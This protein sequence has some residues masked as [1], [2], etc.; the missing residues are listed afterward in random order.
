MEG[1]N[2]NRNLRDLNLI[3]F[4][5]PPGQG[6]VDIPPSAC[7]PVFINFCHS[8]LPVYFVHGSIV[9]IELVRDLRK[10]KKKKGKGA[11]WEEQSETRLYCMYVQAV[12]PGLPFSLSL[13]PSFPKKKKN[14]LAYLPPLVKEQKEGRNRA[15]RILMILIIISHKKSFPA[16]LPKTPL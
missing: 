12:Q 3:G 6:R 2:P 10:G 13:P 14:L 1:R 16:I 11:I 8:M 4:R 15:K 9:W 5:P 7:T